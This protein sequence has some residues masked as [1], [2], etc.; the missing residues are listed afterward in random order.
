MINNLN[1]YKLKNKYIALEQDEN[2]EL[3]KFAKLYSLLFV[4]AMFSGSTFLSEYVMQLLSIMVI[5][6]VL[7]VKQIGIKK[8]C[9]YIGINNKIIVFMILFDLFLCYQLLNTF[10][11]NVTFVFVLRFMIYTLMLVFVM[12]PNVL[13]YII[14]LC[15]TYAFIAAITIIFTSLINGERSGGIV[16]S[17]QY[18]GILMSASAGFYIVDY[19]KRNGTSNIL[20]LLI[21]II[22][23]FIS[24]K[25]ALSIFTFAA[26]FVISFLYKGKNKIIKFSFLNIILFCS[27]ILS[28]FFIPQ[29]RTLID[30]F[31]YYSGDKTYNG[32]T[33][34][35]N[36][37]MDIWNNNKLDGIGMGTY[38][39]Y[40]DKFYHRTGNLE[41]YDAHNIYIQMLADGGL[42]GASLIVMIL[43]IS[44]I[45]TLKVVRYIRLTDNRNEIQL[46][47][48]SLYLQLWFIVYGLSGNPLYGASQFFIYIAGVSIFLSVS[49]KMNYKARKMKL[50]NIVW[51][52]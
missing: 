8:E 9:Y 23:L 11:F 34:Y 29:V 49:K 44:L 18:A 33:Y 46:I 25:R 28:S 36:V 3:G 47:Y 7:I 16:G 1:P 4:L 48:Y 30:R 50:F 24:G 26:Y 12:K 40:F 38:S 41:A 5:I 32:R 17:Y 10:S 13:L 2:A 51:G 52:S 31:I 35:W 39:L 21:I 22:A 43:M 37:A 45:R 42:I 19:Y 27:V 6:S 14:K 15:K 20:G